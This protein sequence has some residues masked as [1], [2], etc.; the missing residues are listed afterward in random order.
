MCRQQPAAY[1][2][3]ATLFSAPASRHRGGRSRCGPRGLSRDARFTRV[4]HMTPAGACA[5]DPHVTCDTLYA[6]GHG[7]TYFV[8]LIP[9]PLSPFRLFRPFRS[10]PPFRLSEQ[11]RVANGSVSREA[12]GRTR[13]YGSLLCSLSCHAVLKKKQTQLITENRRASQRHR[14]RHRKGGVGTTNDTKDMHTCWSSRSWVCGWVSV[15]AKK[16]ACESWPAHHA[17]LS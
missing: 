1:R 10:L 7:G 14:R 17:A 12:D 16:S 13:G 5:S 15:G 9:L 2:P 8:P 6:P 3:V 4:T 11:Q